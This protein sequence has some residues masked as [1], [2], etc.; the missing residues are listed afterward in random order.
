MEIGRIHAILIDL[1]SYVTH[2]IFCCVVKTVSYV[3]YGLHT[4]QP[5][6]GGAILIIRNPYDAFIAE[7]SRRNAGHTGTTQEKKF[8]MIMLLLSVTVITC[9]YFYFAT[10]LIW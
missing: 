6:Y 1:M 8:G 5:S 7:W 3:Y 2:V 4:Q 9:V 10:C